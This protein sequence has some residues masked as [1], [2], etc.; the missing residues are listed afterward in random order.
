MRFKA[1]LLRHRTFNSGCPTRERRP[2]DLPRRRWELRSSASGALP[3][4]QP[5]VRPQPGTERCGRAV[6]GQRRRR[7]D[8]MVAA[9]RPLLGCRR[10][11]RSSRGRCRAP[12]PG[13]RAG[14]SE[15]PER[16]RLGCWRLRAHAHSAG[17]R[18]LPPGC[19][20]RAAVCRPASLRPVPPRPRVSA[21]FNA[22]VVVQSI[23][24]M[25]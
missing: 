2:R 11:A 4:A 14:A 9:P 21:L 17:P 20:R 23:V 22:V 15:I 16:G 13:R 6:P 1:W 5:R 18:S 3:R 10:S 19:T 24:Q 12:A 8:S 25:D 7:G